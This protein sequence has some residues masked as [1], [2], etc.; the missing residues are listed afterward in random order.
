MNA[1][2]ELNNND[3]WLN[4][5]TVMAIVSIFMSIASLVAS[6]DVPHSAEE[7]PEVIA[8]AFMA[9]LSLGLLLATFLVRNY[10][11]AIKFQSLCFEAHETLHEMHEHFRKSRIESL[12]KQLATLKKSKDRGTLAED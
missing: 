5:V 3:L 7:M 2:T 9:G 1:K 12:E 6:Y 8:T 4:V 10:T 11:R